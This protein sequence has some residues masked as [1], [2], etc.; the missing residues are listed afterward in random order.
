[1]T[2]KE[3]L[4]EAEAEYRAAEDKRLDE[5]EVEAGGRG[6]ETGPAE[7]L[8]YQYLEA[9][10]YAGITNALLHVTEDEERASSKGNVIYFPG[11]IQDSEATMTEDEWSS[12]FTAYSIEGTAK[13]LV[14]KFPGHA[15]WVVLPV[16]RDSSG[17][18]SRYDNFLKEW[19]GEGSASRHLLSLLNAAGCNQAPLS[20]VGFSR[21]SAVLNQLFQELGASGRRRQGEALEGDDGDEGE[22]IAP[23]NAAHELFERVSSV[24][25]WVQKPFYAYSSHMV[26]CVKAFPRDW[27]EWIKGFRLRL[28]V[29]WTPYRT[30]SHREDFEATLPSISPFVKKTRAYFSGMDPSLALHFGV[31]DEFSP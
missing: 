7:G 14:D 29:H 4:T 6:D 27:G 23:P 28:K 22:R 1:M 25:W 20:L 24:H 15:I 8:I 5:A 18:R 9:E 21:G 10:G 2:E 26:D 17:Y 19:E 11:D 3:R 16:R 13:L 30:P 31:L 12:A